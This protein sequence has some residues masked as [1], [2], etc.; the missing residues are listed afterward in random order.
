[1][2]E[3]D[4][5]NLAGRRIPEVHACSGATAQQKQNKQNGNGNA[6]RPQ[7]NPTDFT[8]LIFQHSNTPFL[9]FDRYFG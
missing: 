3:R 7:E 8:F 6:Q 9:S 1:M 4:S 2:R 5:L